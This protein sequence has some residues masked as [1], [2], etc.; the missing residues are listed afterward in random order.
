MM[1]NIVIKRQSRI[2]PRHIR[3]Y[4]NLALLHERKRTYKEGIKHCQK[5]FRFESSHPGINHSVGLMSFT[6]R[7]F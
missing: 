7:Q 2:D 1:R 3:T 6:T 5:G 4:Q